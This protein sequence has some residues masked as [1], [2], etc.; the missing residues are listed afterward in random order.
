M[1]K[2][3][4]FY[5]CNEPLLIINVVYNIMVDGNNCRTKGMEVFG[6]IGYSEKTEHQE[7]PL[8]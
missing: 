3:V 4:G 5:I 2:I 6:Y 1:V 7:Q 8:T